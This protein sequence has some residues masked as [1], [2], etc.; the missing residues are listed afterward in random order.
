[1]FS[2][3]LDGTGLTTITRHMLWIGYIFWED[4]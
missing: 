1:M 2:N 4:N 3:I